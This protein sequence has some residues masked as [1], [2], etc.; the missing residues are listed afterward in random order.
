MQAVVDCVLEEESCQHNFKELSRSP[1][2]PALKLAVQDMIHRFQGAHLERYAALLTQ[3]AT[4][5]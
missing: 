1:A 4:L 3:S 2:G 5:F